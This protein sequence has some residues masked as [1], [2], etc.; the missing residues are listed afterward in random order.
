MDLFSVDI[1]DPMRRDN[2]TIRDIL[3]PGR[4]AT[5]AT[6]TQ[7]NAYLFG[8]NNQRQN[9][10]TYG[11]TPGKGSRFTKAQRFMSPSRGSTTA[12]GGTF[13]GGMVGGPSAV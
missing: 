9:E 6:G 1:P 13:A 4:P 12:A 8:T 11:E 5:S 2:Q 10:G 3:A 7:G